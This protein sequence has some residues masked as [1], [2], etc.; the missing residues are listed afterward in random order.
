MPIRKRIYDDGLTAEQR[1]EVKALV[2]NDMNIS[3][4]RLI[5]DIKATRG[6]DGGLADANKIVRR[7]EKELRDG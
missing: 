7:M 1:I 2:R 6:K 5:M 4:C 3:A